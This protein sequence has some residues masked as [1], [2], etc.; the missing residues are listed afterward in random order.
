MLTL[1]F[2]C[3]EMVDLGN[4]A[5]ESNDIVAVIRSIQDEILAHNSQANEAEITTR[6]I[7]SICSFSGYGYRSASSPAKSD[8]SKASS[9]VWKQ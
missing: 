9:L 8:S 4:C 7:V 2:I 5:V 6:F 3:Q 1:C